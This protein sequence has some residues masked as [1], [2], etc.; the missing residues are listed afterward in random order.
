MER[1]EK[2]PWTIVPKFCSAAVPSK[3]RTDITRGTLQA[4][5]F[6]KARGFYQTSIP[7]GFHSIPLG[8]NVHSWPL[9]CS[10]IPIS[11][12]TTLLARFTF[13]VSFSRA[14]DVSLQHVRA[15]TSSSSSRS[16]R[17][18]VADYADHPV[19]SLS[20]VCMERPQEPLAPTLPSLRQMPRAELP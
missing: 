20:P 18:A 3:G 12:P 14:S 5:R 7:Y 8:R 6:I 1:A 9:P 13:C 2:V 19:R 11:A 16:S 17:L 10:L 15:R 4:L